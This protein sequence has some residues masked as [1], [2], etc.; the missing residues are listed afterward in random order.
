[1]HVL[2]L[3]QTQINNAQKVSK[4]KRT[5]KLRKIIFSGDIGGASFTP[6]SAFRFW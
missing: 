6:P 2:M 3:Q 1:M 4:G 5:M